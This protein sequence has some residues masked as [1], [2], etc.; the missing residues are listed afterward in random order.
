MYPAVFNRG[1]EHKGNQGTRKSGNQEI[2]P[3]NMYSFRG[4]EA[5]SFV[6]IIFNLVWAGMFILQKSVNII[7]KQ[8]KFF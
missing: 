3:P 7:Y 8:I 2:N 5:I 4:Q 6:L 1:L